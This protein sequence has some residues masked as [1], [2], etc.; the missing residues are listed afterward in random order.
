M[1]GLTAVGAIRLA[2]LGHHSGRSTCPIRVASRSSHSSFGGLGS[3]TVVT[4][5]CCRHVGRMGHSCPV[6]PSLPTESRGGCHAKLDQA[7]RPRQ[8]AGTVATEPCRGPAKSTSA[9]T[10]RPAAIAVCSRSSGRGS[11]RIRPS[12]RI[13]AREHLSADDAIRPASLGPPV[14]PNIAHHT[15]PDPVKPPYSDANG[16]RRNHENHFAHYA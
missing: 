5:V 2:D 9:L 7:A 10:T 8:P 6:R 14:S 15:L 11:H 3:R 4:M 1:G 16:S 13:T 12:P